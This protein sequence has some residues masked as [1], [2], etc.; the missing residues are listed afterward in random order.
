MDSNGMLVEIDYRFGLAY[1]SQA[2]GIGPQ[3]KPGN[4]S[5]VVPNTRSQAATHVH[6]S[7]CTVSLALTRT[8]AAEP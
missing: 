3:L 6:H 8:M 2:R 1:L 7:L 4:K 5:R